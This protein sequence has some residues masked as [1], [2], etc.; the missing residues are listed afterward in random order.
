MVQYKDNLCD[1]EEA[2]LGK[3]KGKKLPLA[4]KKRQ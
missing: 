1:E 4:V 2:L 3:T